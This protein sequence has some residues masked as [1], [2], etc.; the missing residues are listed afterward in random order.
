MVESIKKH[1]KNKHK[2]GFQQT[3]VECFGNS[4]QSKELCLPPRM[5]HQSISRQTLAD[6]Q[7][8]T[9]FR[10]LPFK[11]HIGAHTITSNAEVKYHSPSK[12]KTPNVREKVLSYIFFV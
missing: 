7:L 1:L 11:I 8:R 10:H 2:N 6:V 12:V 3:M 5:T 4:K 9:K